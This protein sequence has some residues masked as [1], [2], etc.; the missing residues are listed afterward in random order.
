VCGFGID[1][2]GRLLGRRAVARWAVDAGTLGGETTVYAGADSIVVR[3][4]Q[5]VRGL[6]FD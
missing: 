4:A 5:E 6:R 3:G 1:H 2:E